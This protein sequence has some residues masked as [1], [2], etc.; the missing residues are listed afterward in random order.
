MRI[1]IKLCLMSLIVGILGSACS[2]IGYNRLEDHDDAIAT[3]KIEEILEVLQDE[4]NEMVAAT[5]N[6]P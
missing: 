6:F 3:E 2:F 1:R 5:V 4:D